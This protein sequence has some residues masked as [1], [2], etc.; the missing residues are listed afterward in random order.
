M[1]FTLEQIQKQCAIEWHNIAFFKG[2]AIVTGRIKRVVESPAH[3]LNKTRNEVVALFQLSFKDA[4]KFECSVNL[5][6]S[7]EFM[8]RDFGLVTRS[9]RYA[10]KPTLAN[11]VKSQF[12]KKILNQCIKATVHAS[13]LRMNH[14]RKD[15]VK[16]LASVNKLLRNM[17][18]K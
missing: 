10:D 13:T 8:G 18:W 14:A 11:V 2:E 3:I 17:K 9:R 7:N 12:N 6:W 5:L 16:K 4:N 1:S 15:H